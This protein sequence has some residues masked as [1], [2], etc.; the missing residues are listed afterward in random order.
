LSGR[1]YNRCIL[2][3]SGPAPAG[4]TSTTNN[5]ADN[6]TKY[7]LQINMASEFRQMHLFVTSSRDPLR[8][9]DA[10][11]RPRKQDVDAPSVEMTLTSPPF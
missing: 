7:M 10:Q 2:G 1:F 6:F 4:H 3:D 5:Y 8:A 11:H 9:A